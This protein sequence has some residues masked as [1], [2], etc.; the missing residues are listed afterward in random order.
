MVCRFLK[1]LRIKSPYVPANPLLGVYPKEIK[2]E[3]DT[4]TPMFI[5]VLFMIAR[6][7]K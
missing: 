1:K 7:W 4:C 3:R 2:M 6:T 5:A